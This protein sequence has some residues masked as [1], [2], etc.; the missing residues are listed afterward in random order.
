MT[1]FLKH[2]TTTGK[3]IAKAPNRKEAYESGR[4]KDR[5][6]K[7]KSIKAAENQST[8]GSRYDA[9]KALFWEGVR[10]LPF[11]GDQ[12]KYEKFIASGMK[13]KGK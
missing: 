4:L 9:R 1:D 12:D 2:T 3:T 6:K 8:A 13:R 11:G 7:T 10:K 5:L